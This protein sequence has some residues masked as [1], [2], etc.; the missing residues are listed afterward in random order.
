[1]LKH[2]VYERA[3]GGLEPSVIG[4][5][6]PNAQF[7]SPAGEPGWHRHLA[8]TCASITAIMLVESLGFAAKGVWQLV[9]RSSP[10]LAG[11]Q[12]CR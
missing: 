7:I 1:M 6:F 4:S 12:V 11:G 3:D 10:I 2:F 5:A 9:R 8:G